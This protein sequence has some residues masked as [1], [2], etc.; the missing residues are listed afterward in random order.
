MSKKVVIFAIFMALVVG[1][2]TNGFAVTSD[3]PYGTV[4]YNTGTVNYTGY[5]FTGFSSSDTSEID[6][7]VDLIVGGT[8]SEFVSWAPWKGDTKYLGVTPLTTNVTDTIYYY[9]ANTGNDSEQYSISVNVDSMIANQSINVS[10]GLD[11][12]T[13]DGTLTNFTDTAATNVTPYSIADS[14]AIISEDG[15]D[16]YV[17]HIVKTAG[18]VGGEGGTIVVE[19]N[20]NHGTEVN[21][22][23]YTGDNGESFAEGGFTQYDTFYVVII[24][25]NIQIMKTDTV[26]LNGAVAAAIP[27]ATIHYILAFENIGNDTANDVYVS[28]HVDTNYLTFAD[29]TPSKADTVWISLKDAPTLQFG[30][31]SSDWQLGFDS[32]AQWI[33]YDYDTVGYTTGGLDQNDTVYFD[34][35]IK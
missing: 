11:T 4:I 5:T 19:I 6:T 28:D 34:A 15:L 26:T 24:A 9:F 16:T 31:A 7:A 2:A 35:Y 30:N 14:S 12:S 22:G 21:A 20:T 1:F 8:M 3:I 17:L 23:P 18:G 25:P 10:V 13:N 32:R 33:K 27:G 29:S